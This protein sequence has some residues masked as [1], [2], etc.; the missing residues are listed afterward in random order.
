MTCSFTLDIL[1]DMSN[2]ERSVHLAT[3]SDEALSARVQSLDNKIKDLEGSEILSIQDKTIPAL[4]NLKAEAEEIF[5]DREVDISIPPEDITKRME[6]L[7]KGKREI[8]RVAR[9]LTLHQ[10]LPEITQHSYGQDTEANR[11][12]TQTWINMLRMGAFDPQGIKVKEIETEDGTI[13][14]Q[15]SE[16]KKRSELIKSQEKPRKEKV[17]EKA[18]LESRL[19]TLLYVA[20]K[21]TIYFDM[22]QN[23]LGETKANRKL[24]WPQ[25]ARA[26]ALATKLLGERVEISNSGKSNVY[27]EPL[28]DFE[29]KVWD[30]ITKKIGELTSECEEGK[31]LTIKEKYKIFQ[32]YV[33][34]KVDPRINPGILW[35]SDLAT[36]FKADKTNK[37]VKDNDQEEYIA[38]PTDEPQDSEAEREY[39]I[40]EEDFADISQPKPMQ[41]PQWAQA[42]RPR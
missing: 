36:Q 39:S 16:R 2:Y 24:T 21:D 1:Q 26:L 22:I 41:K 34:A 3:I 5:L 38:E 19:Q 18:V 7:L 27:T 14:F 25:S 28:T 4:S 29:V 23:L 8:N 17:N 33:I 32:D 42:G 11:I 12:K 10:A 6:D 40:T 31:Y 13:I 20:S 35:P 30:A 37:A 15:F 9:A